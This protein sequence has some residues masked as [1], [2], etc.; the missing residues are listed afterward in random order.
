MSED[1]DLEAIAANREQLDQQVQQQADRDKQKR[2][3]GPR[4]AVRK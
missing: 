2:P 4:T 3:D 1:K